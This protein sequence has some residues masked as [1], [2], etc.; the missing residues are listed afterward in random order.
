MAHYSYFYI[1]PVLLLEKYQTKNSGKITDHCYIHSLYHIQIQ[2]QFVHFHLRNGFPNYWLIIIIS[3]SF[4]FYYWR[5]SQQKILEKSH[6]YCYI[7][8][9]YHLQILGQSVHNN[10]SRSSKAFP[11]PEIFF[12]VKSKLHQ[13]RAIINSCKVTSNCFSKKLKLICNAK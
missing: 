8:P 13:K 12:A 2:A 3:I 4:Q 1:F 6:E 7:H 11:A 5:S 9:L 10:W